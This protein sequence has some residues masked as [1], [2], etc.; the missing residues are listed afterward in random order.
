MLL[1]IKKP[2]IIILIISNL[3]DRLGNQLFQYAAAKS[4][5]EKNGASLKINKNFYTEQ[6][7]MGAYELHHFKITE[8]FVSKSELNEYMWPNDSLKYRILRKIYPKH[9]YFEALGGYD[10]NFEN[11]GDKVCLR[12][13]WQ[14]YKYFESIEDIIRKEFTIKHSLE[15]KNLLMSKQILNSTAVSVHIR[16]G[17]YLKPDNVKNYVSCSIDYYKR[18]I[19]IMTKKLSNPS[20]YFF[21]DDIKWVKESFPDSD[22]NHFVDFN[23]GKT[24]YEDLRLMTLCKANIIANSTFSWWGAWLNNTPNKIVIAPEKWFIDRELTTDA[25][26]PSDWITI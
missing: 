17:D 12:G 26:Y 10:E 15:G 2:K 14:S 18:A 3:T 11:L 16:R 22:N 25:L 21:S 13:F 7:G 4:L 8:E 20:F 5:A 6:T 19:E 24:A 9:I 23:T 1:V